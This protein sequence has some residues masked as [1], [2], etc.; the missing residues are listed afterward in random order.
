MEKVLQEEN[1]FR[2]TAYHVINKL[3]PKSEALT[4]IANSKNI[5]LTI[6]HRIKK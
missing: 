6:K 3:T 5:Y 2:K 4:I 1:A